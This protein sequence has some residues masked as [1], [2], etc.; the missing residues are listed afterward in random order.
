MKESEIQSFTLSNYG[1]LSRYPSPVNRMMSSFSENFRDGIDI[2]L[3]VGYVNENTIPRKLIMESMEYVI[4]HPKKY[5]KALN[6]GGPKGSQNL[7]NSIRE[8]YIKHKIGGLSSDILNKQE[9]IIGPDGATSLLEGI[10]HVLKPGIV[11]TSD[12]MYY[13]YCNFLMRNGFKIITVPEENDGIHADSVKTRLEELGESCRDIS[14]FYFVT[15]NNPTAT[16]MANEEKKKLVH[17]AA[18]LSVRYKKKIPIFFDK[19]YEDLV[20]DP[21]VEPLE[22]GLLYDDTG[23]VYELGTLSKI[24]APGLRVGY[25]I[26]ANEPFVDSMIQKTSDAG[27]SAPL[28]CQEMASYLLDRHIEKQVKSVNRGY[29]E[30]ALA[31][32]AWLNE[33]LGCYTKEYRGG[34]AGFYYYLTLKNIKTCENS[35]FF[36]YLVRNTGE[37]D[38]DGR[39]A[40]KKP[41]VLYIPGEFCVHPEGSML[42]EGQYQLRISYGFEEVNRIRE[43]LAYMKEAAEYAGSE[44]Q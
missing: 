20:H 26:G 18:E 12:P 3:G 4:N 40:A 35:S 30:K 22:S 13:I 37:E 33:Y 43:A 23:V 24:L 19:A 15:I 17:L 39:Q 42:D 8:Y 34:Q 10:A 25:M 36:N 16:I 7:I 32:K 29:R 2:N 9:I 1:K 44:D 21:D 6:Y 5:N 31:V 28:I 14:F 41:V 27:F 11:I 38:I